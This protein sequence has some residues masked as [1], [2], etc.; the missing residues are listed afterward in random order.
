MDHFFASLAC[1]M[2][3]NLR[4]AVYASIEDLLQFLE[5]YKWGNDYSGEFKRSLPVQ[6]Q[7]VV[8]TVV[9]FLIRNV[10]YCS[11]VLV[12]CGQ[13]IGMTISLLMGS[14]PVVVTGSNHVGASE[15]FLGFIWNY[16]NKL[17]HNC[18]ELFH[19]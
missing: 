18:E 10:S 9:S 8:L 3:R 11:Q 2:S 5:V 14:N 6:P 16:F 17:L 4:S 1:L 13:F 12:L 7:P 15:I 19:F